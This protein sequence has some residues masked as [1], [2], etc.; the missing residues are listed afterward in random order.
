MAIIRAP[1]SSG[2]DT[3]SVLIHFSSFMILKGD[4]GLHDHE[5]NKFINALLASYPDVALHNH[6]GRQIHQ[7]A[8]GVLPRHVFCEEQ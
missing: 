8:A 2:Q 1:S 4:V 7:Y 3:S 5:G 6:E